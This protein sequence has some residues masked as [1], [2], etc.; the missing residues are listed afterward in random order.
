M[1]WVSGAEWRVIL[2]TWVVE[3]QRDVEERKTS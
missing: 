2:V 1:A 3:G